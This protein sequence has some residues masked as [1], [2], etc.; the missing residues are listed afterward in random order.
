MADALMTASDAL[1]VR[2]E[3]EIVTLRREIAE[4]DRQLATAKRGYEVGVKNLRRQL[5]PLYTALQQVF[6]E[7]ET[8]VDDDGSA[9]AVPSE[10]IEK[11]WADWKS[12]LPGSCGKVIDALLLHGPM[13][14]RALCVAAR[15]SPNTLRGGTGVIAR[16]NSAGLW[17]KRDGKFTLREF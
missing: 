17:T 14:E 1:V 13:A 4:K 12:K 6:G 10:R 11:V 7:I 15:I 3:D 16:M 5:A 2:L 9:A 8:L